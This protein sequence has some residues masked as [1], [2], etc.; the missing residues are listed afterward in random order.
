MIEVEGIV[1]QDSPY[2]ETSKILKI[3]TK[4]NGILSVVAKGCRTLKSDLRSATSKYTYAKFYIRYKE[5]GL[6]TLVSADV[7]D[8]FRNLGKDIEKTAYASFIIDL[9]SGVAKQNADPNI[10]DLMIA[11]IKK[12]I[13]DFDYLVITNIL[14]LKYLEYLGVKPMLDSCAICGTNK[15]IVTLSSYKGG[16]ICGN[17]CTN[18][19]ILDSKTVRMIRMFYYVDISKISDIKIAAKTKKEINDFIDEYYDNYTGLYLKSKN[20]LKNLRIYNDIV[21]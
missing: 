4:E 15:N 13:D 6:S 17:C 3:Y 9:A 10:F 20:M 12:I 5:N 8:S 11:A 14:E 2:R 7:I 19:K 1:I 16:Y 21:I 18:E